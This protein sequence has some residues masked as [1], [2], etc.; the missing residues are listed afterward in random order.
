VAGCHIAAVRARNSEYTMRKLYE[1]DLPRLCVGG[2]TRLPAQDC[3]TVINAISSSANGE[4][5]LKVGWTDSGE[6]ST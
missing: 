3:S 5:W 2:R 4:I 1:Q 6:A